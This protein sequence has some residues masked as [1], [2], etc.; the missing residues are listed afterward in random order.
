MGGQAAF[1]SLVE[2]EWGLLIA[3]CRRAAEVKRE[4]KNDCY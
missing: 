1:L 2:R 4:A 3:L